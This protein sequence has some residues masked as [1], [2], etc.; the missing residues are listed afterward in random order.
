M[1]FITAFLDPK[2]AIDVYM[3]ILEGIREATGWNG[4]YVC[5]LR[6]SFYGLKDVPPFGINI[7]TIYSELSASAN[8]STI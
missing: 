7:L 2:L 8:A 1:D 4:S 5:K 6:K 3:A